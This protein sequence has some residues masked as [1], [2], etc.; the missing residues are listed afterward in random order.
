ME[1][2][3][4]DFCEIN[5]NKVNMSWISVERCFE[6]SSNDIIMCNPAY[7]IKSEGDNLVASKILSKQHF[8][9]EK[10]I[11]KWLNS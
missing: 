6:K 9:S 7:N 3:L 10:C 8:C 2:L 4:C 1:K 11:K 5:L